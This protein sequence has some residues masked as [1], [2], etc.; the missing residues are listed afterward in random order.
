MS[1]AIL[2]V[3]CVL[4]SGG[5]GSYNF[6]KTSYFRTLLF[7]FKFTHVNIWFLPKLITKSLKNRLL[8]AWDVKVPTAVS[9][10]SLGTLFAIALISLRDGEISFM[11]NILVKYQIFFFSVH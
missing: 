1:S 8:L 5:R 4:I 7:K 11:E 6:N 2:K 9:N 3:A 10:K